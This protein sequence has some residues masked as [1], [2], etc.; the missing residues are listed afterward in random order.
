MIQEAMADAETN[1][2]KSLRA[3]LDIYGVDQG[4][5]A[6]LMGKSR[7]WVQERVAGKTR[8]TLPDARGFC[9]V[10]GLEDTDV[11]FWADRF[12][13]AGYVADHPSEMLLDLLGRR[14]GCTPGLVS[15]PA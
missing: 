9:V 15:T 12:R 8:V 3:L 5:L 13:I 6:N 10:F 2:S 4:E 1:V 14:S 7:S 11:L